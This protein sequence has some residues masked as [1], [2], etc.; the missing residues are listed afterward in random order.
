MPRRRSRSRSAETLA[1]DILER[2]GGALP[3]DLKRIA[4]QLGCEIVHR[5]MSSE[6]SGLLIREN[7]RVIIAVNRDD[8][9]TRQRFTIAHELGHLVM[10]PGRPLLVDASVRVNARTPTAGFATEVEE[11]EANRFAAALLMPAR[12]IRE[13]LDDLDTL[14]SFSPATIKK[15][16]QQ[17]GVSP[18]AM[19]IRLVNLGLH[20]PH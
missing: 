1:A 5:P 17:F 19:E 13:Q 16:A 10:H 14:G 11:T 20:I 9:R 3:L 8:A 18:A 4:E 7:D 15:M 12:S 2:F 6:V